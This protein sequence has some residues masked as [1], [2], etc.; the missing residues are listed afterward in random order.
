MDPL[1]RH[2]SYEPSP[3]TSEFLESAT[4]YYDSYTPLPVLA[5]GTTGI[6][7]T[8]QTQQIFPLF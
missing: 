3:P 4:P 2:I 1:A 7:N 5:H 6:K 8:T